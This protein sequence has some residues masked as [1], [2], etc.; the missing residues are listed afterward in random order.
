MHD[1]VAAEAAAA[2][3]FG[4]RRAQDDLERYKEIVEGG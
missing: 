3:G 2:S 4:G 1:S